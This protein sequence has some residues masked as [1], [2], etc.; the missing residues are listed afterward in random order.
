VADVDAEEVPG[1]RFVATDVPWTAGNGLEV[2]GSIA[3]L[4]L[5]LASRAAALD[6]LDCDGVDDLRSRMVPSR[7]LNK[8]NRTS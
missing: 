5:T 3:E 7:P 6:Q 2:R 4:L 8:L 1:L